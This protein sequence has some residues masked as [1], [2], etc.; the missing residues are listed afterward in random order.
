MVIE[1][2]SRV[3]PILMKTLVITLSLEATLKEAMITLTTIDQAVPEDSQIIIAETN[4]NIVMMI[5]NCFLSVL[6]SISCL[7]RVYP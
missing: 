5:G 2:V 7:V 4:Q 3:D 6:K 1:D